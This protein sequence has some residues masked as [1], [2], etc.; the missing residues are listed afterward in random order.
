MTSPKRGAKT[1]TVFTGLVF[2]VDRESVTLP[3]GVK[4]TMDI[5]RHRGSVV[6]L[7]QPDPNTV[8]LIRQYRHVIGR[9]IWELPA[10]TLEPGESPRVAAIRECEEETGFRPRHVRRMGAYYATPGFCDEVMAFYGCRELVRPETPATG[11]DDEL[12]TPKVFTLTE[13]DSLVASGKV[14]DMKT[15]I[16]LELIRRSVKTVRWRD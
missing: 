7:V 15:V 13:A 11:D 1:R 6:L 16:G 14:V 2:R 12:I 4:V 8:I 10:G 3:H 9:S 5:V